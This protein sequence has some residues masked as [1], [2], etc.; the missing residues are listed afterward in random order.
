MICCH[1]ISWKIFA[2][3]EYWKWIALPRKI[4]LPVQER[5][6]AGQWPLTGECWLL[7]LRVHC[8][9]HV[10]RQHCTPSN[11][12][13]KSLLHAPSP[14]S[15]GGLSS[16]YPWT[17]T[18]DF[19]FWAQKIASS[20]QCLNLCPEVGPCRMCMEEGIRLTLKYF[21]RKIQRLPALWVL[22]FGGIKLCFVRTDSCP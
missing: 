15:V 1:L 4:Q 14:V 17:Q 19:Q 8:A 3:L 12:F 6:W 9:E 5:L 20:I 21:L 22:S 2:D 10:R 16:L 7:V 18:A 11:D 13:G